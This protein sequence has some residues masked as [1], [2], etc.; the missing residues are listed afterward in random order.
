V[1]FLN[2][3]TDDFGVRP[4]DNFTVLRLKRDLLSRSTMEVFI[5]IDIVKTGIQ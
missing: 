5:Q 1:G 4:G 2:A 3:Q